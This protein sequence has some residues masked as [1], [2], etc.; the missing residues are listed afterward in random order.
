MEVVSG[1]RTM[2]GS[3]KV[4]ISL[5]VVFL[6]VFSAVGAGIDQGELLVGDI[7]S[8]NVLGRGLF[9]TITKA[10]GASR[11]GDVVLVGPGDYRE[12]VVVDKSV[13]IIGNGPQT[14]YTSTYYVRSNNVVVQGHTFQNIFSTNWNNAAGVTTQQS[15]ASTTSISGLTVRN[16]VFNN[17]QHGVY[18]F[19]ATYSTVEDCTFI[20]SW[21]GV[22]IQNQVIG[23]GARYS[24]HNTVEDCTFTNL[25]ES[26]G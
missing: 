19:G 3:H 26:A 12:S 14:T 9:E 6:L 24:H 25:K 20:D 22:S 16:C 7:P 21:R 2:G 1:D 17:V 23:G 5:L 4:S 11:D 8:V 18:L 13:T 10:I 15:H